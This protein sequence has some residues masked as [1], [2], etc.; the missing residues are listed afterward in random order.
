[1][2]GQLLRSMRRQLGRAGGGLALLFV[3]A[4]F[5]V[6]T[7]GWAQDSGSITG[8]VVD[9]S[10]AALPGAQIVVVGTRR[11]STTDADGQYTI[12]GAPTGEIQVRARFVGFKSQTETIELGAG[13]TATVD[14][15]LVSDQLGMEEVVVTGSFSERSKME[16]SVAVTT[17]NAA[18]IE[19]QNA[20]SISDL[21]KSVPGLWVESSGG[22]G[23]NN[24]FT[25]GLPSAGKLTFVELNHNGLPVLELNDLD[26]GNTDQFFR[27]DKTIQTMEAVRGGTASIFA[28]SA[29]AAIMNFRSKTGGSEL[30]GTFKLEA[31]TAAK[32]RP[33]RLR[34]DFNIGGPMGEDWQFNVGGFYRF[35]EGV[36]DPGFTGNQGGQISGNVT[37]F[38]DN[39]YIRA[40]GRYMNDQNIFYL[41]VPLRNPSDGDP[42][43][44]EGFDPNYSTFA[45]LD[46]SKV[47]LPSSNAKPGQPN[48]VT[49]DLTEG[50]HPELGS[51]QIDLVLDIT[52]RLSLENK[53]KVMQTDLN[54]NAAF[55]LGGAPLRTGEAFAEAVASREDA[56]SGVS[57]F[58]YSFASQSSSSSDPLAEGGNPFVSEVGWWHV[59]NDLSGFIEELELTYDGVEL[60]GTHSFTGGLY[61]SR[62]SRDELWQFN[63]MLLEVEDTPRMLDLTI[64]DN[65]GETFQVTQNGLS[66][67][68]GNH[69]RSSGTTTITAGYVGDEWSVSEN[70]RID[71]GARL[72]KSVFRG[73]V[74]GAETIDID[75][76]PTTL[77]NN[78]VQVSSDEFTTF[79]DSET[80]WAFSGGFNYSLTE[81]Y[82]VF[83]R[84]SRGFHMQDLD[85]YAGRGST[86]PITVFQGELGFKATTPNYGLFVTGFWSTL[87]DQQ[88]SAQAGPNNESVSFTADTRTPGVEIEF[89]GQYGNLNASVTSTIQD[90]TFT[91]ANT[92]G[93]TV[94]DITD[95]RRIQRQPRFLV[96]FSPRYDL[97]FATIG[98]EIRYVDSRFTDAANQ[99]LKLPDYVEWN[100]S[101]TTTQGP[102]TVKLTGSNLTNSL[103]LTE[104]NPRTGILEGEQTG[105]FVQARPILGRRFN[106]SL[107]YD[108]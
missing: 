6:P 48:F 69:V 84:F 49:R 59:E 77:F 41:P 4:L 83:G 11:G 95:D 96:S 80:E 79:N 70:L 87:Q 62:T 108:F 97:G 91:E 64:T 14:F 100:A 13:E 101:V 35:D 86:E 103:G 106:V 16:S 47:R 46:A 98:S 75:S 50:I 105:N 82:A 99:A 61:V 63:N 54:F 51:S 44:I 23:G 58:N 57:D 67:F 81:Q 78:G 85:D 29:P 53:A 40:Y 60:A 42:E 19:E 26:F 74:E 90:P 7:E 1:M 25:R 12:E 31:G 89:N 10:G 56:V 3:L 93:Q 92:E 88:F 39:G 36:R 30:G 65:T 55:S 32:T 17:L 72:E 8:T 20:Q 27:S 2:F 18:K 68:G 24:V 15:T 107:Q 45:N 34:T 76:D 73:R 37:R 102:V 38:L 33:G 66:Q 21:M 94:I 43:G 9:Q 28:A 22:Q 52:D 5:F 71:L 104:G